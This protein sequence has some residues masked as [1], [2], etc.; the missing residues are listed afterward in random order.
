MHLFCRLKDVECLLITD[1][2]GEP[3]QAVGDILNAFFILLAI[4]LNLI[5]RVG[6]YSRKSSSK[7]KAFAANMESFLSS[8]GL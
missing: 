4:A 1:V 2:M 3:S 7:F 6:F 5:W 8:E